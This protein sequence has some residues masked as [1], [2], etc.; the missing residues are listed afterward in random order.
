MDLANR[1]NVGLQAPHK[2]SSG[3]RKRPTLIV[4]TRCSFLVLK[5]FFKAFCLGSLSCC[6]MN[7]STLTCKPRWVLL[8]LGQQYSSIPQHE[9][10]HHVFTTFD[11]LMYQSLFCT[12]PP[13]TSLLFYWHKNLDSVKRI[14]PPPLAPVIHH[15]MLERFQQFVLLSLPEKWLRDTTR[16]LRTLLDSPALTV[17]LLI[18]VLRSLFSEFS[19]SDQVAFLSLSEQSIDLLMMWSSCSAWLWKLDELYPKHK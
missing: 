16:P 8:L 9:Y 19:S 3:C 12:S 7:P 5:W 6:S 17:P 10:Y 11:R 1:D 15:E 14:T 18:G 4:S 2:C 13:Y